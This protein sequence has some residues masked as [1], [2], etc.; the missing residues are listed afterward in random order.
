MLCTGA[1]VASAVTPARGQSTDVEATDSSS[2][3]QTG[4]LHDRLRAAQ[5]REQ[6][7]L[8]AEITDIYS[9][10]VKAKGKLQKAT[11]LQYSLDVS[12]MYQWGSPKAGPPA[13]QLLFSPS[14]NWDFVKNTALGSGSLQFAYNIPWYMTS[15]NA[16]EL[17]NKLNLITPINDFP[18]NVPTFDQLTL[19]YTL[20][21]NW[22]SLVVGQFPIS[23]FD[24]NQYANNQQI[25]FVSYPLAQNGSSTYPGAS[26]GVYTQINPTKEV[27]FAAGFQD[28][29]NIIGKTIQF[30][31]FGDG[32]YTWF[33]YGQW[34][35]QFKGLGSSQ[36]SFLYYRSPSVPEQASTSG[37]SFNGVQNLTDKWGLFMRANGANGYTT[38]IKTSI[39]GGGVLNN[40][41][42]RDQLDQIGLGIA[43]DQA[44][45]PPTNPA[46]A[47]DEWVME[48]YWAR[49]FFRGLQISPDV[50]FYIHPA[51]N[52][53]QSNAWVFSLRS[54][55]LF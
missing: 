27:S 20:P 24:A 7:S 48:A 8:A 54:L 4:K 49:T 45:R 33:V 19:T 3:K 50:Q 37:W 36:F 43:W 55:I 16:L 32:Q 21:R 26:L 22:L 52:P 9:Q 41:L 35:P 53:G 2:I 34:N 38:P 25:N 23:N 31:T 11:D 1:I 40:P 28:A 10:Y 17:Q 6:P 5:A 44:A 29:N 39:A 42:N 15:Q 18:T 46:N 14:V 51:L 30:N 13:G 12:I 47:R